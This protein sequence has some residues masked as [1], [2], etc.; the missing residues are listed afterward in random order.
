M[1]PRLPGTRP[2]Q[3]AKSAM[4]EEWSAAHLA[5]NARAFTVQGVE[6]SGI[7]KN[8]APPPAASARLPVAAPSHSVRPGSLKCKCASITAGKTY[9]PRASISVAPPGSS[10][11]TSVICLPSIA[12]SAGVSASGV[13]T[14]PPRTT[15]S[16]K[17]GLQ[18]F[19][20]LQAYGKAGANIL[21]PHRFLGLMADSAR[22]AQKEHSG[23]H[24]AGNNHGIVPGSARHAMERIA[25]SLDGA[26]QPSGERGVHAH[27]W[28]IEARLAL[29]A[30][31]APRGDFSRATQ[32]SIHCRM[33]NR[34]LRMPEIQAHPHQS[35]YGVRS[36]RLQ[37]DPPYR[38]NQARSGASF[39]F[40]NPDPFG[41]AG[42]R[43]TAQVH[44]SGPGVIGLALEDNLAPALP[45]NRLHNGDRQ[46]ETFEHRPLLNVKFQVAQRTLCEARVADARGVEAEAANGFGDSG[47]RQRFS[48][49]R[50]ATDERNSETHTLFF[51]EAH[52]LEAERK[53]A[54]PDS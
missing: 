21:F 50:A 17:A 38:S 5:S 3:S 19:E 1:A 36:S 47:I 33:P 10:R 40:G 30:K 6:L 12:I 9:R 2:P 31:P 43:V 42:Q 26:L 34:V 13:T 15:S 22:S 28:L 39:P 14:I 25:G 8:S 52:H 29:E 4:E 24:G 48:N 41:G 20:E 23:G 51:G 37:F 54:A 18:F 7:S 49:K 44:G 46:V 45:G 53:P 16:G 35:R 11:P 27:G 32:Q